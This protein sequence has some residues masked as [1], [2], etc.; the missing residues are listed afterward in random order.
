M[1]DGRESDDTSN[2]RSFPMNE[3]PQLNGSAQGRR[4]KPGALRV[5]SEPLRPFFTVYT[6]AERLSISERTMRQ[7]LIDGEIASYMIGGSRRVD[8]ADVE[9]YLRSHRQLRR[10]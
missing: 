4:V 1:N 10:R 5:T 8:P 6:L 7:M 9:D 2:G 3:T